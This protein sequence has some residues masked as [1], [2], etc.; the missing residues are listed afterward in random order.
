MKRV[1]STDP[2]KP[3]IVRAFRMAFEGAS[4]VVDVI[5]LGEGNFQATL[6]RH[7]G[8]RKYERLGVYGITVEDFQVAMHAEAEE[9]LT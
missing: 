8:N 7:I 9:V 6:H 4:K 5:D 1:K 2:R 3:V